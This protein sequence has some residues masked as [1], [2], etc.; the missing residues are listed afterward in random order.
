V[1]DLDLTVRRRTY[2][3]F[4]ELGRAPTPA[5]LGRDLGLADEQVVASWRRLHDAH[6]SCSP[7]HPGAAHGQSVLGG[8]NQAILDGLGLSGPFWRLP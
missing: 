5:E 8:Q 1:D 2:G 3:T 6:G 7:R 4:V